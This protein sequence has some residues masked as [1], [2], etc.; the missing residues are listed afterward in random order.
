M[1]IVGMRSLV[2]G[3]HGLSKSRQRERELQRRREQRWRLQR[4]VQ[5]L[6]QVAVGEQVEAEQRGQIGQG[7]IGLGEMMQPFEEQQGDQG[8]PNLNAERILAGADEGLHGQILL[9][10]FEEQ[11]DLPAFFVDGGDRGGAELQQIG[12]QHDLALVLLVPN[13]DTPEQAGTVLFGL[14]TGETNDLIT[15]D[16]SM[17]GDLAVVDHLIGGIVFEPGDKVD[18]GLG[19]GS[20]QS[21][22]GIAAVHGDDG[23]G[24]QGE[25]ISQFD[26]AAPGFGK[27]DIGGQ[28][29]VVVQQHMGLHAA[30]G[31]PELGP[32]EKRQAQGDGGGIQR[33]QFVLETELMALAAQRLLITELAERGPEQVFKQSRRAMFVGVGKR[34]ERRGPSWIPR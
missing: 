5:P 21:V 33:E 6:D 22:V 25:R 28:V 14:G 29:I 18:F 11:F 16:A 3:R 7:P 19:P 9:H 17:G 30:F 13:D 10:R 26:I 20:K 2:C 31:A 15:E 34:V 32:R 23:T 8:C 4:L 24:I 27:Q 12:E 1:S